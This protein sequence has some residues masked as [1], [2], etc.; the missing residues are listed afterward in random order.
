MRRFLSFA[1]LFATFASTRASGAQ[2][3]S[4]ALC[5]GIATQ[6]RNTHEEDFRTM[7]DLF[8]KLKGE[9]VPAFGKEKD[10]SAGE[11]S[12]VYGDSFPIVINGQAYLLRLGTGQLGCCYFP[13]PILIFYTL[14][15]GKLEPV[16]SAFVEKGQGAL[17][18]LRVKASR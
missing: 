16:G 3:S 13:G 18:S 9:T 6:V 11:E 7:T 14:R 15:D 12:L 8:S 2:T 4:T 5:D 17:E 10:L 1:C